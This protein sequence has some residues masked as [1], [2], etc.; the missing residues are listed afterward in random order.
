MGN[1]YGLIIQPVVLKALLYLLAAC[2]GSFLVLVV[3]LVFSLFLY[4][5]LLFYSLFPQPLLTA[6]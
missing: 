4:A 2:I 3:V 1:I 5:R 6:E